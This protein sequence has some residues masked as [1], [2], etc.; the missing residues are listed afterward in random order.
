MGR[1]PT[2][3]ISKP[4]LFTAHFLCL[5]EQAVKAFWSTRLVFMLWEVNVYPVVESLA[6]ENDKVH[7][8]LDT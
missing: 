2:G 7:N 1:N 5:L 6:L 8:T 3:S 4:I